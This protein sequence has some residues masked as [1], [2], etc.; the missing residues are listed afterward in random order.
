MGKENHSKPALIKTKLYTR[1]VQ[2]RVLPAQRS[3]TMILI[4]DGAF[5]SFENYKRGDCTIEMILQ[6]LL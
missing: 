5:V 4:V 6:L 1:E 3:L 2:R